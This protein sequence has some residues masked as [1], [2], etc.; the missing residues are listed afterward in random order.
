[1]NNLPKYDSFSKQTSL[2]K[3]CLLSGSNREKLQLMGKISEW[4]ASKR[5]NYVSTLIGSP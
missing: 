3:S 5:N 1:M 2:V 4:K